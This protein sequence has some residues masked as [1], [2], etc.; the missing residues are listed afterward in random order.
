MSL[1]YIGSP[2]ALEENTPEA[3]AADIPEP[4]DAD[5][6]SM[7]KASKKPKEKAHSKDKTSEKKSAG[8]KKSSKAS[9]LSKIAGRSKVLNLNVQHFVNYIWPIR[10]CRS[11]FLT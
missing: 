1:G 5:E 3:P 8:E 9:L 4:V 10:V 11:L 6:H 7:S 2:A